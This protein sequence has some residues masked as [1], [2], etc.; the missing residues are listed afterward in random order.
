MKHLLIPA[1]ALFLYGCGDRDG[2]H[3]ES[4]YLGVIREAGATSEDFWVRVHAIEFLIELG[5]TEEALRLADSCREFETESQKRIGYWRMKYRLSAPAEK[6]VWLDK[7]LASY[8]DREGPDRIHA[9]E[10]LAKLSYPLSK[11]DSSLTAQDLETGG[12]LGAYVKWGMALPADSASE[13]DFDMLLQAVEDTSLPEKRI[14]AYAI[15]FLKPLPEPY[16][17]RLFSAAEAGDERPDVLPYLLHAAIIQDNPGGGQSERLKTRLRSLA[18]APGKSARIELCKALAGR[19][20]KDDEA[21]LQRVF[22]LENPVSEGNDFA[23]GEIGPANLDV[24]I[25]AA[26][27][28]EKNE[29]MRKNPNK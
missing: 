23:G 28:L 9:A 1:L 15:T 19:S 5:D 17:M 22:K 12:S 29:L 16:R 7:I 18:D 26:F 3:G 6:Q 25:A 11:A 10:T 13:V 14:A 20:N 8:V 21:L 4:L 27:A 24:K 2:S